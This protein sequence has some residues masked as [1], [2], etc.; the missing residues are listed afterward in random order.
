[1]KKIIII[2]FILIAIGI[3]AYS[4]RH[5]KIIT[6]KTTTS[7]PD[8]PK[9]NDKRHIISSTAWAI[10]QDP[11]YVGEQHVSTFSAKPIW[12]DS[13]SLDLKKQMGKLN[14]DQKYYNYFYQSGFFPN[15]SDEASLTG[16]GSKNRYF[17]SIGVG[18]ASCHT[19]LLTIFVGNTPYE[20]EADGF[21]YP[22]SDGKGFYL[23]NKTWNY[24][25]PFSEPP[26]GIELDRFEWMGNYFQEVGVKTIWFSAK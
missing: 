25:T 11:T 7:Y 15:S 17:S 23:E 12:D 4:F 21:L 20:T 8:E 19:Q 14:I 24:K 22:R 13:P 10:P 3:S 9:I 6:T 18:C 5:Q 16:V 2:I 26:D 1:M